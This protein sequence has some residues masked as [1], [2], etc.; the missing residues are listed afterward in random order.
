MELLRMPSDKY[1]IRVEK[2]EIEIYILICLLYSLSKPAV[3]TDDKIEDDDEP[4]QET[5]EQSLAALQERF[6]ALTSSY[7]ALLENKTKM[8]K[9]YQDDKKSMLVR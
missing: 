8:E 9:V 1:S 7:Q 5:P 4:T 2:L 6:S 3:A